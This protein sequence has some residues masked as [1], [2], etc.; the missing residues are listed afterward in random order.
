ML[1]VAGTWPVGKRACY[2]AFAGDAAV[3]LRIPDQTA[4]VARCVSQA[5]D[6]RRCFSAGR[7][8]AGGLL[9]RIDALQAS[10]AARGARSTCAPRTAEHAQR[11]AFSAKAADR[12]YPWMRQ[13]SAQAFA[14]ACTTAIGALPLNLAGWRFDHARCKESI[15]TV[16]LNRETGATVEGLINALARLNSLRPLFDG[17]DQALLHIPIKPEPEPADNAAPPAARLISGFVSHFQRYG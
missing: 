4:E 2:R 9:A 1:C 8:R 6:R 10:V 14:R 13:A 7:I 15:V 3:A 17:H 11:S 12:A 5:D 16:Q